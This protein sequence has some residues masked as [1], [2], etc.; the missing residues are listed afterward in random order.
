MSRDGRYKSNAG[1]IAEGSETPLSSPIP[2]LPTRRSRHCLLGFLVGLLLFFPATAFSSD[3]GTLT[4]VC[5]ACHGLDGISLN[6]TVPT[7]AGQAYTLLEDS[8]LDYRDNELACAGTELLQGEAAAL[9][10]AMCTIV[11]T[12][13]N[14][15]IAALAEFYELQAFV[16]AIQSFDPS[17]AADGARIHQQANCEHCH[18]KGGRNSNG[19]AAIL[20]GQW[21]P[22]LERSLLRIRAGEK[23]GPKVMNEAI[24]EFSDGDIEAL[25]NYYASRQD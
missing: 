21:T 16:P 12:L 19:M 22:Y 5:S 11:A 3:A 8:L 7:I 24:R 25:L 20:A 13:D 4:P 6:S 18:S 9:V 23:K 1:A 2:A 15:D 10:S 17:L 14:Q